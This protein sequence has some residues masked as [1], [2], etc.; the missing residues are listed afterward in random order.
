MRNLEAAST[1]GRDGTVNPAWRLSASQQYW[2]FCGLAGWWELLDASASDLQAIQCHSAGGAI[3]DHDHGVYQ[4]E[5]RT[6]SNGEN[7]AGGGSRPLSRKR[8][9]IVPNW[10]FF[11][12]SVSK[13]SKVPFLNRS[14]IISNHYPPSWL[15]RSDI[16]SHV[17]AN[18][19][20]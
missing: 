11:R 12:F 13:A 9:H 1:A 17:Y 15:Y 14:T 7:W 19:C 16:Q 5:G 8:R 10:V 2:D 6:L 18:L 4:I 3:W 20:T